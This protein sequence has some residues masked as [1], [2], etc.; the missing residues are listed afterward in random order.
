[1]VTVAAIR[2]KLENKVFTP[3]GLTVILI[4][5][6]APTTDIRGDIVAY[7]TDT[8]SSTKIVPYNII[9][10]RETYE[11]FGTLK[12]GDMDAAVRYSDTININDKFVINSVN[13]LIKEIAPNYLPDNVVTIVRLTKEQA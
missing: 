2:T 10:G 12:E 3:Y 9:S 1:M 6:T 11:A 8:T 13:Y 4:S 7:G 5:K